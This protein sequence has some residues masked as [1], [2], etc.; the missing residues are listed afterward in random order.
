MPAKNQNK[1]KK[2]RKVVLTEARCRA[3]LRRIAKEKRKAEGH[4][5]R[6]KTAFFFFLQEH[7]EGIK[8]ADPTLSVTQVGSAAGRAWRGLNDDAKKRYYELWSADKSRYEAEMRDFNA[9]KEAS[10]SADEQ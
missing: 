6:P 1:S 3:Y 10:A 5:K 2:P 9:K 8:R 7:R 4:P